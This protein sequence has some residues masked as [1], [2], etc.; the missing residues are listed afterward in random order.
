MIIRMAE[1][2]LLPDRLIRAGI[3]R[4]LRKRLHQEER[5]GD[6][7][8]RLLEELSR[9]PIAVAQDEANE[10]HYEVDSRF[11]EKVLGPHLKYSSGYWDGPS[12]TLAEAEKSMLALT[13]ERAGLD[14]GQDVL[15]LGCGWGSLSLWMAEQYPDS[16]ITSISNSATQR[17]WITARAA[18]L[19]LTNLR[20]LTADVARFQPDQCF[21]RVVSVEMFEHM[22]NHSEL[23]RRVHDWLRPGGKLF[24]HIFCHRSLTYLFETEGASNWMGRYFFTGGVMPAYDWL[25]RCAG[26]LVEEQ[27]WAVNGRH[28]GRTLE[29]WRDNADRRRDELVA[30]LDEGYGAGEGALWLQRWRM[31]FMACAELFNYG[32]GEEWFVGHYLFRRHP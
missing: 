20:V 17:A 18:R 6:Q 26:A 2:G 25:P 12:S 24:V 31:F 22:R 15:E 29:A 7:Q 4:L 11:Y 14:D 27:R 16:R 10:Q 13:C 32:D 3:H 30:L 8:P 23:M 1:S 21:D 28:Y 19:G 5:R 9:G